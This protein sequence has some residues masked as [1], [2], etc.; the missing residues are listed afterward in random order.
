[1]MSDMNGKLIFLEKGDI[2]F[3]EKFTFQF[4][5]SFSYNPQANL[6]D[7]F[8]TYNGG[9]TDWLGIDDGTRNIPSTA[10]KALDKMVNEGY[11]Q[12]NQVYYTTQEL[13]TISSSFSTEMEP[14]KKQSFLNHNE[15]ISLGDQV[16]LFGKALGYNMALSYENSY[17]FY[18]DGIFGEY[19]DATNVA[20]R[21][22]NDTKGEQNNKISALLN[23]SYKLN[24][25][26]KLGFRYFHNQS[27]KTQ[28]RF[29]EGYFNYE[30]SYDQDRILAYIER[31]FDNFQLHGKHV[32]KNLNK[33]TLEWQS[34]FTT[35]NQNEPDLRFFENLFDIEGTDSI[36]YRTKT[37]DK[38][39][40]YYREMNEINSSNKIDL[41]M[42]V[43]LFSSKSKIKV[44]GSFDYKSRNLDDIKFD[45]FSS[46]TN[47]PGSNINYYLSNNI[48]STSNPLG[49][50]YTSDHYQ[51]LNN[52]QDAYLQVIAGYAMIDLPINDKFRIVTGVRVESSELHTENKLPS[53]HFLSENT[54]RNFFDVLPSLNL[55]YTLI[56]NMNLRF[57]YSRTIARPNFK[58]IGPT[59]YDFTTSETVTG[60]DSLNIT[61]IKS[62]LSNFILLKL[63]LKIKFLTL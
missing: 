47:L 52:S 44:G 14:I 56:E 29:R 60:N 3:P 58:E 36:N 9:N 20:K 40:R 4:S 28:A 21:K 46:S 53:T 17:D 39:A 6:N 59:Y 49:Y 5:T 11:N 41:E 8:I 23:L 24:N 50:Y 45:L 54:T 37:N 51:N 18:D 10:Q 19:E 12:I 32:I 25:N 1:M 43:E 34:S 35:M 61:S 22:L 38:P 62:T 13:N 26:N 30:D 7:D 15:K 16:T 33:S 2:D 31:K 55:T 42:P 57:A 48:I 27:G 63:I